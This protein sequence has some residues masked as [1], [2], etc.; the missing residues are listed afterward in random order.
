AQCQAKLN[1]PAFLDRAPDAVV[2]KVRERLAAAEADL[3]RIDSAL[4]ALQSR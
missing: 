4:A 3:A 1:N 2:A